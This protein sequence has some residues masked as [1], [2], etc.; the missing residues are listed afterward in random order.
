MQT[1]LKFTA[2][3]A[4]MALLTVPMAASA[5]KPPRPD[6]GI[7]IDVSDT[8]TCSGWTATDGDDEDLDPDH[9]LGFCDVD[10]TAYDHTEIAYGADIEFE[11]KWMEGETGMSAENSTPVEDYECVAG[12]YDEEADADDEKCT[13]TGVGVV[14]LPFP[15]GADASLEFKVKGFYNGRGGQVSRN[16]IKA[17]GECDVLPPAGPLLPPV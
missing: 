11:A 15:E 4:A 14:A 1:N 6:N 16:F 17:V 5:K 3:A 12:D 10:W 13:A 8:C 9:W 2:L 7:V